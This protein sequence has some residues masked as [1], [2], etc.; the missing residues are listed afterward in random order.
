MSLPMLSSSFSHMLTI[1]ALVTPVILARYR[2][3]HHNRVPAKLGKQASETN[4]ARLKKNA[5][6]TEDFAALSHGKRLPSSYLKQIP[7]WDVKAIELLLGF[8]KS[9]PR[10]QA[11][12]GLLVNG[13][14][15]RDLLLH[16]VPDDLDISIC[17]IGC[18][19]YVTVECILDEL[20]KFALEHEHIYGFNRVQVASIV[21]DVSKNKMLDTA[22][23]ILHSNKDGIDHRLEI[24]LMPT[25]G[26]EVYEEAN[27]IPVRDQRG[28][29]EQDA[30]RRDLT[31]GAMFIKVSLPH[32]T[33]KSDWTSDDMRYILNW[34]L[35]DYYGGVEDIKKRILRSPCPHEYV[36]EAQSERLQV[37]YWVKVLQ[38]DPI[39][40]I[41]VLRFAAK[42]DFRIHEA[43]WDA[44]PGAVDRLKSKVAGSR[45]VTEL[46]KLAKY[47]SGRLT[48]LMITAFDK[49][50]LLAP[51]LFGGK[52]GTGDSKFFPD[53]TSFDSNRFYFVVEGSQFKEESVDRLLGVYLAVAICNSR[54]VEPADSYEM[55]IEYFNIACDGMCCSNEM[56][57][58]GEFII[59][60][61]QLFSEYG[62]E[63]DLFVEGLDRCF[64]TGNYRNDCGDG[65]ERDIFKFHLA[66]WRIL[67]LARELHLACRSESHLEA[68]FGLG[69]G[70]LYSY[71]IIF[72]SL[73]KSLGNKVRSTLRTLCNRD[74]YNISGKAMSQLKLIPPHMRGTFLERFQV[75]CKIEHINSENTML[76]LD[77]PNAVETVFPG[78]I[79]NIVE[80]IY[81]QQSSPSGNKLVLKEQYKPKKVTKTKKTKQKKKK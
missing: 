1:A 13:G 61:I 81:E 72:R 40:I 78:V 64:I 59:K 63:T 62:K 67:N 17:L 30:L 33:L 25:I 46:L 47:G 38:D 45:K 8:L 73:P 7:Y 32:S 44:L 48:T 18:D 31:I 69:S 14:Y 24:D 52:D 29:P 42:L 34:T 79:E 68:T 35:L 74:V 41:R 37:Q 16:R 11:I 65:N 19:E 57:S 43:F 9:E 26:E 5:S 53:I 80:E 20:C 6:A 77:E 27:R 10:L 23:A 36:D 12:D 66:T 21:G 60:S 76:N 15:V 39:R 58:A 22:K 75:L 55:K 3:H 51:A 56:R 54:F 2:Y 49:D 50:K 28:T 4:H 71:D 70:L